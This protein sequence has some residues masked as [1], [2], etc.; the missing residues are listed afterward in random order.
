MIRYLALIALV[1]GCSRSKQRNPDGLGDPQEL[2]LR[3]WNLGCV[4]QPT[5]PSFTG[6]HAFSC[7]KPLAGACGCGLQINVATRRDG[8]NPEYVNFLQVVV[9]NCPAGTKNE[10]LVGFVEPLV[11]QPDRAALREFVITPKLTRTDDQLDD[12]TVEQGAVID[13]VPVEV[14]FAAGKKTPSHTVWLGV[15]FG[16]AY[17]RLVP[18]A[19]SYTPCDGGVSPP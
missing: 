16:D 19:P 1:I 14:T 9:V 6:D 8:S 18:G 15:F 10:D 2:A 7:W 17:A 3:A 11:A 4:K 12:S 13:H 5:S